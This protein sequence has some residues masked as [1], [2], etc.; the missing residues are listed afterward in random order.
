MISAVAGNGTQLL[1][2]YTN[3]CNA[4]QPALATQATDDLYNNPSLLANAGFDPISEEAF[5]FGPNGDTV[6]G[7]SSDRSKLLVAGVLPASP[8][9]ITAIIGEG[10]YKALAGVNLSRPVLSS[11]G[12]IAIVKVNGR[13]KESVRSRVTDDFPAPRDMQDELTVQSLSYEPEGISADGRTLFT[14]RSFHT[15][16]FTRAHRFTSFSMLTDPTEGLDFWRAKPTPT[17]NVLYVTPSGPC[18]SERIG[19]VTRTVAV[20]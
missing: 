15:Y 1:M 13:F 8:P 16:I 19:K 5:A 20:P 14:T 11:D 2:Q 10:P 18:G 4:G 6:V 17:C 12:L 3:V 9:A 7:V